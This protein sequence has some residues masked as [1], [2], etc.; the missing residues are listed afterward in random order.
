[1][2]EVAVGSPVLPLLPD[3]LDLAGCPRFAQGV[4]ITE[5]FS[6]SGFTGKLINPFIGF[7]GLSINESVHGPVSINHKINKVSIRFAVLLLND[8]GQFSRK[9]QNRGA[10]GASR[11]EAG[12]PARAQAF[13][14]CGIHLAYKGY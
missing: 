11:Q 5:K 7:N 13:V 8:F 1:M 2:E 3:R 4:H 6:C 12:R 10:P 14:Q 9:W